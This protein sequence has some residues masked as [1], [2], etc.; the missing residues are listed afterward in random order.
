MVNEAKDETALSNKLLNEANGK[1]DVLEAE[2]RALKE[3]VIT[4][5]PSEP[6]KHLH[7]QLLNSNT[8][9]VNSYNNNSCN[10]SASSSS[11][12]N[13]N[14]SG[15]NNYFNQFSTPTRSTIT[16]NFHKRTPS[17]NDVAKNYYYKQTDTFNSKIDEVCVN[18]AMKY[19]IYEVLHFFTF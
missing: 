9:T 13:T 5:T 6:N 19:E 12:G 4:S 3:L 8:K 17:Y 14:I 7:P 16:K 10:S 15:N 2:V 11:S 18:P 1:I